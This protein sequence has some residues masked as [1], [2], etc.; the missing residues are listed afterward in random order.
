MIVRL[1]AVQEPVNC[2]SS[3]TF[4]ARGRLGDAGAIYFAD[5]VR[6]LTDIGRAGIGNK[7]KKEE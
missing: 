5:P 1:Q 6:N 4:I 7:G 3:F 2:K